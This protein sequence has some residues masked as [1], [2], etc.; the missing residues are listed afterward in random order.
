[1][2]ANGLEVFDRTLQITNIWL[3]EIMAVVGPDRRLA[4]RIFAQFADRTQLDLAVIAEAEVR[5]GDA[6]PDF[7]P[8]YEARPPEPQAGPPEA[9]ARPPEAQAHTGIARGPASE[10]AGAVLPRSYLRS[11]TSSVVTAQS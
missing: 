6:A 10:S 4:W 5:R 2:S 8:L 9:Q 11:T 7:V 3:D 1:M